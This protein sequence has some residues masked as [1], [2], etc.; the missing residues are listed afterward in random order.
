MSC[1]QHGNFE[2]RLELVENH[3][4]ENVQLL[5]ELNVLVRILVESNEKQTRINE[6]QIRT[7]TSIND[8]LTNFNN[9]LEDLEKKFDESE[10]K[11]KIDMR[12]IRNQGLK[13]MFKNVVFPGAAILSV[14]LWIVQYI[15]NMN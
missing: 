8:N 6:E 13:D 10:E 7:L 3:E 14:V 9:R 4:R 5:T 11:N 12:E 1:E 15:Q 2:R